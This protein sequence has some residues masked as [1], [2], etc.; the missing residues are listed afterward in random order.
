MNEIK[1]RYV[2][3]L[4]VLKLDKTWI[5]WKVSSFNFQAFWFLFLVGV[6]VSEMGSQLWKYFTIKTQKKNLEVETR[7][8]Q[9]WSMLSEQ[10][11]SGTTFVFLH[12]D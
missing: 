2:L 1:T 4:K 11:S 8:G 7:L 3:E 5:R 6:L 12:K 10:K 9:I